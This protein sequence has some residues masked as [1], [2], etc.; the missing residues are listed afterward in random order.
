MRLM[1]DQARQD[2]RE[3]GAAYKGLAAMYGMF[4]V[5]VWL[6]FGNFAERAG[7]VEEMMS[8][9]LAVGAWWFAHP[10]LG[11]LWQAMG[12]TQEGQPSGHLVFC[13]FWLPAG[14]VWIHHLTT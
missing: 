14:S 12:D 8:F 10:F 1:S 3:L 11:V 5:M 2:L 6:V 7:L 13:L 9:L 4:Y